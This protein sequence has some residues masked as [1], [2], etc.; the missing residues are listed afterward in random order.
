MVADTEHSEDKK[1]FRLPDLILISCFV[2]LGVFLTYVVIL[3][4]GIVE[5]PAVPRQFLGP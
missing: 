1:K 3:L 4:L 5:L 2:L